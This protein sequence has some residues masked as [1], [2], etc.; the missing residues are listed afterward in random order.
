MVR[1]PNQIKLHILYFNKQNCLIRCSEDGQGIAK[2]KREGFANYK[3]FSSSG[4]EFDPSSDESD[5]E[6]DSKTEEPF[7][8]VGAMIG[9]VGGIVL[10]TTHTAMNTRINQFKINPQIRDR[11]TSSND[12]GIPSGGEDGDASGM[13]EVSPHHHLKFCRV[14][15][16]NVLCVF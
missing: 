9:R 8:H 1:E 11:Q 5:S 15:M 16:E 13:R 12:A 4:H 6:T 7:V 14:S 2:V 3:Y 10:A